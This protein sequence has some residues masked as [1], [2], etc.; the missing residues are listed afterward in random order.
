MTKS[1]KNLW[2]RFLFQDRGILPTKRLLFVFLLVS[3]MLTAAWSFSL[4]E[5]L[6]IDGVFLL[7]SLADLLFSPKKKELV[8]KRVLPEE[9]ERGLSTDIK[10]EVHNQ[11]NA[12]IS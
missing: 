7:I 6:T 12:T 1:L 11:G 8:F 9:I 2:A 3:L 5:I 4:A 10:V